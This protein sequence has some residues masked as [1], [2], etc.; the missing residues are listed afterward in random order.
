[1][2]REQVK[3]IFLMIIIAVMLPLLNRVLKESNNM[4]FISLK[5]EDVESIDLYLQ[6]PDK[7]I[8]VN[9]KEKIQDIVRELNKLII[10]KEE[11]P[12]IDYNVQ[13]VSYTI[14]KNNKKNYEIKIYSPY[15]VID[16]E[17]F[18]ADYEICDV[19]NLLGNDLIENSK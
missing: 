12:R 11:S 3:L 17:I 13:L 6:P 14:N 1:M 5:A 15:I 4:P 10:K 19:L 2:K 9:N 8:I 18:K 7:K 16:G